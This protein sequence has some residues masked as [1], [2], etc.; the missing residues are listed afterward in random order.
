M[1]Y[2][3]IIRV[4]VVIL[5]VISALPVAARSTFDIGLRSATLYDV[6]SSIAEDGFFHD[7][8]EGKNWT[9]GVGLDVRLSAFHVS[10][11]ASSNHETVDAVDIYSSLSFDV[12]VIN[13]F[14]Y[15]TAGTG[16]TTGIV[17]PETGGSRLSYSGVQ[18]ESGESLPEVFTNS[19]LHFKAGVDAVFG[20]ATFSL[21]YMRQSE[22]N[23]ND[24]F[25]DALISDGRNL[26]GVSLHLSVM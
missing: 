18:E 22:K 16:V 5:I 13:D 26:L 19:P 4:A 21:Y 24:G 23:L 14:L 11:L 2:R 3:K 25:N 15:L 1:T 10:V 7:L 6:D 8:S 20:P 9:I 17:F 12:P